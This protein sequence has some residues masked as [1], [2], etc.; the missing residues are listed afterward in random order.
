MTALTYAACFLALAALTGLAVTGRASWIARLPLLVLTPLLA[1]AVWWQLTQ[2]DGWP[3]SSKPANGSV[4]VASVVQQPTPTNAGAI[5]IWTQPPGTNTP[6][7]YRLPYDPALE[8]QVAQAAHVSRAGT[9]VAIRSIRHKGQLVKRSSG[10]RTG[11]T[12]LRFYKLPPPRFTAKN[13]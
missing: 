5:F 8:Q 2:R 12:Q 9:P 13:S 3:A 1:I 10:Q 11:G 7:A 6:R 4:F